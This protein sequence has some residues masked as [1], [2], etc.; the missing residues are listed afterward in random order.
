MAGGRKIT[1]KVDADSTGYTRGL[2]KV[3]RDT[4]SWGGRMKGAFNSLKGGLAGVLGAVAGALLALGGSMRE[5]AQDADQAIL[6]ADSL[7]R[8]AGA[9][10]EATA[11][12]EE[13]IGEVSIALGVA[14][15]ELR[16]AF[17]R[18]ATATGDLDQAQQLLALSLDIAAQTGAPLATVVKA[19]GKASN[20]SNGPLEK[21][22]G[23]TLKGGKNAGTW[24]ANQ[25]TLNS[26][27]GGAAQKKADTYTGT[28]DRLGVAFGEVV[29]SVG[30]AL[31]PLLDD[32]ADYLSSPE[33][34]Q[35]MRDFVGS[36]RDLGTALKQVGDFLNDIRSS[37]YSMPQWLR[38]LLTRAA[39]PWWTQLGDIAN[40]FD[41]G[42]AP[43]TYGAGA[44]RTALAAPAGARSAAGPTVV[45]QAAYDPQQTARAVQRLVRR[46]DVRTGRKRFL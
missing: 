39:M 8:V 37:A 18:L 12:I 10:D 38:D 42:G 41:G 11:S 27:F 26:K 44:S 6:L 35:N 7:K 17:L 3:E 1:V 2:K 23:L 4:R 19:V 46:A 5:A 30:Q 22:T 20:G 9:S 34:K 29:E 40:P 45:V 24:A 16:P 28:V 43:T 33:G 14:D 21:L 32:L 36:M 13:W 31:L 15:S 25:K